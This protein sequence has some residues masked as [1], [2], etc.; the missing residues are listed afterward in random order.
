MSE[1]TVKYH[2]KNI[3]DKLHL[4]NRAEVVAYAA[5]RGWIRPD[6]T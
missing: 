5:R 1:N 3:L 4:R 6:G 2:I